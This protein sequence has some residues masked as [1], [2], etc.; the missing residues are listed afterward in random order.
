MS[1]FY[2][3]FGKLDGL[4]H[5]EAFE[6]VTKMLKDLSVGGYLTSGT[7]KDWVLSRQR[8]WGVPCPIVYC[9]KCKVS[10]PEADTLSQANT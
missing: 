7:L 2:F 10:H 6:R 1:C 3:A 4:P 8:Y 9:D 5:A